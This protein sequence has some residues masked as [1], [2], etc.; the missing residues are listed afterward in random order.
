MSDSKA[1]YEFGPFRIDL[2]RYLLLRGEESISLS[3]KVFETL[4]FL[5]QHHG[6]VAKKD[7]IINS[8]WPETFVEEGNLAQNVFLL[9]RA[10]GE[11]KNEH[12]YI[13][14]IP[15]VGYRF[16][17]PVKEQAALPVRP[18][19]T[20]DK[21]VGSIAVLPFKNLAGEDDDKFLGPGLADALIMRLSSIRDLKVKPTT[22]VLKFGN[23]REDPLAIGLELNV[24]ALLD[25]VY[26][27]ERD[28][29]R[30]SVQL[31]S[32]KEGVTL[33]AAKFDQQLTDIFSIQDSISEQVVRSLALEL[34]RD[35]Q[36]QLK[37]SYTLNMEAF[38]LFVK[39]RYFWNQ[40]TAE[41][42]RKALEYAQQAIAVDPT[43]APAYVG[44]ADSYSLLGAQHTVLSPRESF[45]KARAAA[46][47]ALEIDERLAEAYA[48]LGFINGC[49]EWDWQASERN[50]L[51]AIELKPNYATAHHWYGELLTLLGRFDEAYA[52]LRMAQELDPLSLAIN[53][54]MAGSFYYSRQ[55]DKSERQLLNLLELNPNFVRAHM[56][57]GKV[58]EQ[59][60]E[61]VKA[62]EMLKRAVEL[63]GDDPVTM[64]ALAHALAIAGELDGAGRILVDLQRLAE[65]RYVS[66]AHIA[67]I[68][69]GLGKVD[70]AFESLEQAY[71]NRDVE[72]V[73]L[74]VN[75][76]F[77]SLRS[78]ARF[79]GLVKRVS[80]LSVSG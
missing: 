1:T 58:H 23:L 7:D 76:I 54:D 61:L 40:R 80:P 63:S 37:E 15:G 49:Y 8:I 32:V 52:E 50:Y 13:V 62:V 33:W 71:E 66:D 48:S 2:E 78:D 17:A 26:Q 14:T 20:T 38:Q 39:G 4:L 18:A 16:V 28:T 47:R 73:W 22:A 21:T 75:P 27:R 67:A 60:G 30:V 11:D 31:V 55:Y 10:L 6:E 77:D 46:L 24:D 57:L 70:Q 44:L 34:N 9:R 53:V 69:L 19:A 68:Q 12:R 56:L 65:R 45:P 25:G 59:K 5:V 43:Y 42:L 51:K 72:I 64:A 29:I 79:E 3:P 35:E 36:R 74:K 41:A